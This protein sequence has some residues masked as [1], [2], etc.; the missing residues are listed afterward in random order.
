MEQLY[1]IEFELLNAFTKEFTDNIPHQQVFVNS[2]IEKGIIKSYTLALNRSKLWMVAK[3]DN[4]FEIMTLINQLP[5]TEFM[6][7]SIS[8]LMFHHTKERKRT[9]SLN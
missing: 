5:L 1:M 9:F 7:P 8:P 3:A 6:I 2:F 4:E